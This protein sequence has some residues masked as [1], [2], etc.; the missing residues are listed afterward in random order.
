[1]EISRR[2]Q[3]ALSMLPGIGSVAARN[4]L[5]KFEDIEK[6]FKAKKKDLIRVIGIGEYFANRII[7][8]REKALEFADME[9]EFMAKNEINTISIFDS[10]YPKRLKNCADAPMLLYYLGQRP[11]EISKSIGI[12]GTRLATR[13][14]REFTSNFIT[15]LKAEGIHPFIISGLAFGIDISAHI[16]AME[17]DLPTWAVL[18]HGFDMMYPVDHRVHAA[19]I[20]AKG[21][22]LITEFAS[23][24]S[25]DKKNFVRRN[26]IVAGLSDA[27]VVVESASKGGSLVTADIANSYNKDVFAVQGRPSDQY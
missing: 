19:K 21:G 25:K 23:S 6:V 17:N 13:R 24:A 27:V 5:V 7:D 15:N 3:V 16:A 8:N 26:R 4:L 20:V 1:M 14:G 10:D 12:V 9:L 18:G 11:V 2:Y 22:T